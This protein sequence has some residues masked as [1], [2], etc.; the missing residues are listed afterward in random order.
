MVS[1]HSD[2]AVRI[3]GLH[4]HDELDDAS[5]VGAA[6][7]VVAKKDEA[8]PRSSCVPAAFFEEPRELP[9]TAVYVAKSETQHLG[10]AL[11]AFAIDG[12]G[13]GHGP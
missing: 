5:A 2:N 1:G 11:A 9:E 13:I 6:V 12:A 8:H 7:N 4:R 3:G 10:A